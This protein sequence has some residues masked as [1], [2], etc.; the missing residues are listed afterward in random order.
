MREKGLIGSKISPD[1]LLFHFATDC[2]ATFKF[3][4]PFYILPLEKNGSKRS[5]CIK[6]D[7]VG[8]TPA[9]IFFSII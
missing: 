5:H 3:K 2:Q 7:L 4:L 9:I 6:L 1:E 8:F